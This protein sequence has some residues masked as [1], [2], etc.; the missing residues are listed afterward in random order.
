MKVAFIISDIENMSIGDCLSSAKMFYIYDEVSAS[1]Y[2]LE[3][4]K[5]EEEHYLAKLFSEFLKENRI[6]TVVARDLGPKAKA[7]LEEQGIKWI[8]TPLSNQFDNI[9][10]HIKNT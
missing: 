10:K 4:P 2:T 8:N 1:Y 5:I 3:L 7:S 9:I 6:T